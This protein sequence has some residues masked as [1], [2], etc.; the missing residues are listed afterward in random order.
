MDRRYYALKAVVI[1]LA[2]G[3]AAFGYAF[4]SAGVNRTYTQSHYSAAT[5]MQVTAAKAGAAVGHA[6]LKVVEFFHG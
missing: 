6:V 2:L 5:T 1:V 4:G 3:F